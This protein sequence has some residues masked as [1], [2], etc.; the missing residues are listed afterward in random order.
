MKQIVLL[1]VVVMVT[2]VENVSVKSVPNEGTCT[3]LVIIKLTKFPVPVRLCC[4]SGKL[5]YCH[6]FIMF[7][8]I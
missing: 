1:L 8:N 5:K 6:Y 7:C 4:G 3:V 2:V